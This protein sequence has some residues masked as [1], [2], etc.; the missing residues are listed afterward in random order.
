MVN[1]RKYIHVLQTDA[2]IHLLFGKTK[3]VL[4]T[5]IDDATGQVIGLY[6]DKEETLNGYYNITPPSTNYK[7][8]LKVILL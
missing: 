8:N 6:F 1:Y 5:A 4:H 7:N 2:Y 3:T